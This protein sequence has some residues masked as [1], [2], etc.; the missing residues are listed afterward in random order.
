MMKLVYF[1]RIQ[2]VEES[3]IPLVKFC[4]GYTSYY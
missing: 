3:V 1:D 4:Q 2:W